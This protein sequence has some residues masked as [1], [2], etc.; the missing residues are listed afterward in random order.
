M[1]NVLQVQIYFR[2]NILLQNLGS[3]YLIKYVMKKLRT[4]RIKS[5]QADLL[6]VSK[7]NSVLVL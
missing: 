5:I 2:I 7:S 6:F 3:L 1:I 4:K